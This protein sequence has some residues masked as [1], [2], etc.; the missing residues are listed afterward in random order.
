MEVYSTC[1]GGYFGVGD[2][3]AVR[4][5]L[6]NVNRAR[7]LAFMFAFRTSNGRFLLFCGVIFCNAEQNSAQIRLYVL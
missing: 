7:R 2:A 3:I 6:A 1:W 5:E 4:K